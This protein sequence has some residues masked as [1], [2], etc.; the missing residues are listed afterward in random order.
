M[1]MPLCRECHKRES[2]YH[3]EMVF[4][5][6]PTVIS[7]DLEN[8]AFETKNDAKESPHANESDTSGSL[9]EMESGVTKSFSDDCDDADEAQLRRK[10]LDSASDS[11]PISNFSPTQQDSTLVAQ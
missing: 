11:K 10:A 5:G 3:P 1:Y 2:K 4:A 9:F 7:V 6:D 8:Q